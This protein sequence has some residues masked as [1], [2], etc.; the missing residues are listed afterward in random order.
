[1]PRPLPAD[2]LAHTGGDHDA[3][4]DHILDA[5]HRV[6]AAH[7]LAA[8]STRAIATEAGVGAGTLYN[9]FADRHQLLARSIL[10]QGH[11]HAEPLHELVSLAGRNT[12]G[13][14][15][16]DVA[17]RAATIM[18]QLVPLLAAAFSDPDLL[19]AFRRE[20]AAQPASDATN[21]ANPVERYLLAERDLGRIAPDAD[22][23][24]AAATLMALN[25]DRA[26][27][28]FLR[29]DTTDPTLPDEEI[30]L[31]TRALGAH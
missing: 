16:R 2:V 13:A 18:D 9:Y 29:G 26:F 28:R 8:A 23:G 19:T 30:E 14:N 1:M 21:P 7:G 24:A 10:R 27:H 20:I 11:L 3:V 4:R 6:M 15:L 22:C 12:V 17:R 31:L 5:A 25:H